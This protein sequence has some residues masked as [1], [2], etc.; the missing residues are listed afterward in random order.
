MSGLDSMPSLFALIY[1]LR[2]ISSSYREI[3]IHQAIHFSVGIILSC[4][5]SFF[6]FNCMF[7]DTLSIKQKIH[8][9]SLDCLLLISNTNR[10][11]NVRRIFNSFLFPSCSVSFNYF[12]IIF[13]SIQRLSCTWSTIKWNR[14]LK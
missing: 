2:S 8:N 5:F 9:A 6:F 11:N 4:R 14:I 13:S 1:L 12:K 7:V 10:G 3:I